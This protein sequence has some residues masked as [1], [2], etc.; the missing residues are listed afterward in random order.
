VNPL[1]RM[2]EAIGLTPKTHTKR[3]SGLTTTTRSRLRRPA[4]RGFGAT[5]VVAVVAAAA[6][7]ILTLVGSQQHWFSSGPSERTRATAA[8]DLFERSVPLLRFPSSGCSA[9]MAVTGKS[10]GKKAGKSRCKSRR[11]RPTRNAQRLLERAK[12]ADAL[13][14]NGKWKRARHIYDRLIGDLTALCAQPTGAC[15]GPLPKTATTG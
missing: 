3:L 10:A 15:R 8:R 5:L 7:S 14:A 12:R 6:G 9:P 11:N 1:R 4:S 13:Y 2:L